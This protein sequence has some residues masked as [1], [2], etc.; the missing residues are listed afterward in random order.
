MYIHIPWGGPHVLQP[1]G[2]IFDG[3]P[4][5]PPIEFFEA[6]HGYSVKQS[7]LDSP[8]TKGDES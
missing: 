2:K 5:A 1:S 3:M 6:I 7:T 8:G 4:F